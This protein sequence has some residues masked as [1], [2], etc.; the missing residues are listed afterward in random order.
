MVVV[1]SSDLSVSLFSNSLYGLKNIFYRAELP[2]DKNW[3][4]HLFWFLIGLKSKNEFTLI[5]Q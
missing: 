4:I 5:E 2:T 1:T 3:L